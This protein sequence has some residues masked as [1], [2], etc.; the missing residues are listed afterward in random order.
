[1][2]QGIEHRCGV[3]NCRPISYGVFFNRACPRLWIDDCKRSADERSLNMNYVI[4]S[5][6]LFHCQYVIVTNVECFME[7]SPPPSP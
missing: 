5:A 3:Q 4:I 7:K 6:M 1:M 2:S